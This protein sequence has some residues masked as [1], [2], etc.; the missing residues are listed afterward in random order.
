MRQR[1]QIHTPRL[2]LDGTPGV[3]PRAPSMGIAINSEHRLDG[4][5]AAVAS[6]RQHEA[7]RLRP[8]FSTTWRARFRAASRISSLE[9]LANPRISA[10]RSTSAFSSAVTMNF[11]WTFR[12]CSGGFGF[13]PGFFLEFA[14]S[15]IPVYLYQ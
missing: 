8:A 13:G 1:N 5:P 2:F 11:T 12:T 6:E 10:A 14:T 15:R 4:A 9:P 3:N 7:Q